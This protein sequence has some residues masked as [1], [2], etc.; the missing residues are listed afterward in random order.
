M[1]GCALYD[2]GNVAC[3]LVGSLRQLELIQ[4]RNLFP[5]HSNSGHVLCRR[6]VTAAPLVINE[7]IC[8][9]EP[10]LFAMARLVPLLQRYTSFFG[11]L[12]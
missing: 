7:S 6:P 10:S 4:R 12:I 11:L 5:L 2:M 9:A 1:P 8:P 3:L